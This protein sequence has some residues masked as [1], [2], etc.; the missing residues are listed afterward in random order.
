MTRVRGLPARQG[1]AAESAEAPVVQRGGVSGL[2]WSGWLVVAVLSVVALAFGITSSLP[3]G[4]GSA[5]EASASA[6]YAKLP[7]GFEPNRGQSDPRVRFL[8]RG[9][10]YTL[11]L[12]RRERC[13]R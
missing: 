10:G 5:P 1:L 11:F 3:G 9:S 4:E 12:T 13:F 6:A 8:S 2:G 7:I